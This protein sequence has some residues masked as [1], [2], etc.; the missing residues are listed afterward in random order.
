M[1]NDKL[2]IPG[3]EFKTPTD[4]DN[5]LVGHFGIKRRE[6]DLK[7]VREKLKRESTGRVHKMYNPYIAHQ[8]L[9]KLTQEY[10]YR[11]DNHAQTVVDLLQNVVGQPSDGIKWI[12]CM[13]YFGAALYI[14]LVLCILIL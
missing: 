14:M 7:M 4:L 11:E 9:K 6:R 5:V 3:F 8:E 12:K 10:R 2:N 1:S 13:L